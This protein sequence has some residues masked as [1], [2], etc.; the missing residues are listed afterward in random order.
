MGY[1]VVRDG[2]LV[3]R[4]E[5]LREARRQRGE[6]K[7]I[8]GH[9]LVSD[10]QEDAQRRVGVVCLLLPQVAWSLQITE[11]AVSQLVRRGTLPV[12]VRYGRT[13]LFAL[14]EVERV[15]RERGLTL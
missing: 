6:Q 10:S 12:Y 11:A 7:W 8:S 15:A 9:L 13:P 1:L 5:A 14:H 4:G 2:Q 3:P